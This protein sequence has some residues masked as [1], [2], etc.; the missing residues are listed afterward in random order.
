MKIC[1]IANVQ[2]IH[3]KRWIEPLI[4]QGYEIYIVNYRRGAE[5]IK[6]AKEFIDLSTRFQIPKLRFLIWGLWTRRYLRIIKPDILH[7]HQIPAAG[8]IGTMAGFHPFVVS[9]WGSDLLV[10]PQK[11]TMRRK[12]FD[13]VFSKI[14]HLTVP[15]QLLFETAVN[16]DFPPACVHLI[17][18]GVDT[19]AREGT[20]SGPVALR[21]KAR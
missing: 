12:L 9:A 5:K 15:S 4:A 17:P 1:F 20:A 14:D 18:W 10:E 6:G 13:T 21:R 11:S 7:A 8:W 3:S 2:S 19:D 16:L